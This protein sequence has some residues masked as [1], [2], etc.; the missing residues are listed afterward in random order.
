[1]IRIKRIYD[2]PDENDG[3]RVL[4]DRIWP[5]GISRFDA[6]LDLWAQE[7]APS[8]DLRKWF[9][10][11]PE[12]WKEFQKRYRAELKG[13]QALGELRSLVRR[14]QAT[15]LYGARD[16]EHNH[17]LV[18]RALLSRL[19]R[20]TQKASPANPLKRIART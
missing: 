11:K 2:P 5:Q 7:V 17:A 19:A 16:T 4:V 13:N 14:K 9:G 1:M 8:T 15:L 20:K 12:R 6:K 10:H 3:M 18:L